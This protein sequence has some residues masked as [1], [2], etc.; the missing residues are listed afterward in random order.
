[1]VRFQCQLHLRLDELPNLVK[2]LR[3][4]WLF[5]LQSSAVVVSVKNCPHSL[6]QLFLTYSFAQSVLLAGIQSQFYGTITSDTESSTR[7]G[8][9]LLFLFYLTFML[10][11]SATM[12]SLILTD[13]LGGISLRAAQLIEVKQGNL[14][15][16]RHEPRTSAALLKRFNNERRGWTWVMWHCK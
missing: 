11:I 6:L 9:A 16:P 1:M 7:T 12:S 13:E 14:D 15:H 5:S 3:E 4:G 8:Q 2:A 10:S